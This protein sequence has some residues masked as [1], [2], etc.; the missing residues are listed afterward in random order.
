LQFQLCVWL[1]YAA[2]TWVGG[3]TVSQGP[4]AKGVG[5]VG[6]RIWY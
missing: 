4:P 2:H 3:A 5:W 6:L 1:S